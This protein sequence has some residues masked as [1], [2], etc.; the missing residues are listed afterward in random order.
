MNLEKNNIRRIAVMGDLHIHDSWRGSYEPIFAEIGESAD[1]L[2][3]CGD[4]TN[5]G[6]ASEARH[7]AHDLASCHIPVLAVLGNHDYHSDEVSRIKE[8]L[9]EK[10]IFLEDE[11]YV[12]GDLG[13]AGV[14]GF[15]GGFNSHMLASF[16]EKE[17]KDY[18]SISV[19]EALRLETELQ[20]LTT[21]KIVVVLHYSPIEETVRGE[22]PEIYSFLGNSRLEETINRFN[23]SF[24]VHG[25]AHYGSHQG[26]TAKGIP[27]YNCSA[28][29]LSKEFSK[30]Y[31]IFEV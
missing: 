26:K 17:I 3:L 1:L 14:K 20:S 25:H 30:P 28:G 27:V 9:V 29:L 2:I 24:V 6:L 5:L 12:A 11:T 18:V 8:V 21:K 10:V 23:V 15:S 4:L 31:R 16:G 13:V 19:N 22:P 7:L